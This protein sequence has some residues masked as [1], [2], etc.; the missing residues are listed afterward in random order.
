MTSR[1]KATLSHLKQKKQNY[2]FLIQMKHG[3]VELVIRGKIQVKTVIW[4]KGLLYHACK[5]G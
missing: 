5:N 4:K 3:D 2:I 1:S